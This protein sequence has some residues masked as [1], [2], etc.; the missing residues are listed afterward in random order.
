MI[1]FQGRYDRLGSRLLAGSL[2]GVAFEPA[3][4]VGPESGRRNRGKGWVMAAR[5]A[6]EGHELEPR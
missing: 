1:N 4:V 6:R 3:P 2:G 5:K